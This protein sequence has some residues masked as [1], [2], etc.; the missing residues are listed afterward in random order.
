MVRRCRRFVRW[1]TS[2]PSLTSCSPI[3]RP[4]DNYLEYLRLKLRHMAADKGTS[5]EAQKGKDAFS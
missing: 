1:P 3:A 2:S 4:P 5:A